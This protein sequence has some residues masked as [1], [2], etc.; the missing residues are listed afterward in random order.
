MGARVV[1]VS[2]APGSGAREL[3]QL[4]AQLLGFDLVDREIL[5]DAAQ[6][7]G[8]GVEELAQRDERCLGLRERL[9]LIMR[10]FLERGALLGIDPGAGGP[11]L[12][13]ILY[14][15]YSDIAAR[16]EEGKEFPEER[17]VEVLSGVVRELAERGR[18][19][20]LGRGSHMILQG[21]P[22][23]L[24]L[25]TIA[26][27]EISLQRFA[28]REGMSVAEA[29]P[30]FQQSERG[31]ILFYRR[32]WKVDPDDPTRYHLTVDTSRLP[33]EAV[34]KAVAMIAEA[35]D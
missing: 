3:S 15:P 7:L 9:A 11:G 33:L 22:G 20:I 29:L 18:V 2:G 12:E 23:A 32:Y 30:S 25:L 31:R 10:R 16:S 4:V 8:V 34:A 28:A 24:H 19:V 21:F 17:Y 5:A 1:T 35:V 6:R 14:G 26:P 27:R 13:L